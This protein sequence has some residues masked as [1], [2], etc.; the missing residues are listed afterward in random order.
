MAGIVFLCMLILFT[1]IRVEHNAIPLMSWST[2]ILLWYLYDKI[3]PEYSM[4]NLSSWRSFFFFIYLFHDPWLNIICTYMSKSLPNN[5]TSNLFTFIV[6]QIVIISISL[7]IAK[8]LAVY[9]PR[10]YALIT[11][12]RKK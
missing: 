3:I 4:L 8:F 10:F 1:C 2:A 12:N 6:S 11:G 5:F 9:C 7:I